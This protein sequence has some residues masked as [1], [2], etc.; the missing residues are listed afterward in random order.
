MSF[1]KVWVYI[2]YI[3]NQNVKEGKSVIRNQDFLHNNKKRK[4]T[5]FELTDFLI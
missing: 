2:A 3:H 1:N 4:A 5:T